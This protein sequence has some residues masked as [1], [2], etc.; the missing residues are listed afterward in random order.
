FPGHGR[1]AGLP[2]TTRCMRDAARAAVAAAALLLLTGATA[3]AAQYPGWGDTGWVYASKRECCNAAIDVAARYSADA[4]VGGG[5]VP[6][7]AG[8]AAQRGPC[9]AEWM[10][11]GGSVVYRCYGEA[12]VWCR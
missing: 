12:S 4:C 8:G 7:S 6:R 3:Q 5:G 2:G 10:Q 1:R 9:S 11:H